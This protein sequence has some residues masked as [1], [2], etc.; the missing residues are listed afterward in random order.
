M[1]PLSLRE[2][3]GNSNGWIPGSAHA[4][5]NVTWNALPLRLDVRIG[6]HMRFTSR[7]RKAMAFLAVALPMLF[8]HFPPARTPGR[9][10]GDQV[11]GGLIACLSRQSGKGGTPQEADEKTECRL[12]ANSSESSP[13]RLSACEVRE[14]GTCACGWQLSV[15][16]IPGAR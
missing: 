6:K 8:Q 1:C 7:A 4:C 13:S 10:A 15:E 16:A 12:A 9:A 2:W 3:G 14:G 5:S 11:L